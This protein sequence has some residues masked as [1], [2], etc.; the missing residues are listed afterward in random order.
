M[1]T[2]LRIAGWVGASPVKL[3]VSDIIVGS[4]SILVMDYLVWNQGASEVFGQIGRAHV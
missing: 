4:V 2:W 1:V 3:E